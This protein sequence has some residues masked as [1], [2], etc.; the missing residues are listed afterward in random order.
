MVIKKNNNSWGVR[1]GDGHRKSRSGRPLRMPY[2]VIK[3]VIWL[4][5]LWSYRAALLLPW[6]PC[7]AINIRRPPEKT[8]T[9]ISLPD[10][11]ETF[12]CCQK[13]N[14]YHKKIEQLRSARNT[15]CYGD[16]RTSMY[17]QILLAVHGESCRETDRSFCSGAQ[18][19]YS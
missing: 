3:N 2:F 7:T 18:R 12:P 4:K 15:N 11:T 14:Y 6:W 10:T 5:N 19:P 9:K 16:N 8:T 13:S 1:W 17:P